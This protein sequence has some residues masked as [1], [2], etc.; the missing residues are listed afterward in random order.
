MLIYKATNIIT[1]R[2]YVGQTRMTLKERI[3]SHNKSKDGVYFHS[4]I[5]KYGKQNFQWEILETCESLNEANFLEKYYIKQQETLAPNG[6]NL[7]TGGDSHECSAATRQLMSQ[8][9]LGRRLNPATEIKPGQRLSPRTEFKKGRK[10]LNK[11]AVIDLESG[12]TWD[13]VSEA[14]DALGLELSTL[15]HRLKYGKRNTRFAFVGAE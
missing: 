12:F 1:G 8:V 4:A 5:Q 15:F 9:R 11:K 6:Y 14:A 7:H 3:R 10:A 13:S 2:S